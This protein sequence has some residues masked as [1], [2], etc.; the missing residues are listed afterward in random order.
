MAK[1]LH[2]RKDGK[3][4]EAVTEMCKGEMSEENGDLEF[5]LTE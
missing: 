2:E 5:F 4:T 1:N 3:T